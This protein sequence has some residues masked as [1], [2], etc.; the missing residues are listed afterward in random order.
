MKINIAFVL[1]WLSLNL[2]AQAPK[3]SNDFLNIGVGARG[4]AMSGAA[5]AHTTTVQA[6]YWNPACLPYNSATFQVSA[7]HAEWFSGIGNYDY[8]GFGKSLDEESRS[9]GALSLIRMSIDQIPNTLRLRGP[10]GSIDYSRIE[11]FSVADY[12]LL[13]SYGRKL[14]TG[15]WSFGANTKVI[16]RSFGSFAKAWGFGIDAG[17]R[18]TSDH[19]WFSIMGRDITTTFNAYKFSFTNEEKAV[20]QQTN[21]DIPISSVEYTLPKIISSLAYKMRCSDKIYLLSALDLEFSGNGTKSSLISSSKFN[22]DPKIG[23]ELDYNQRVFLRVGA[24]NFQNVLADDGSGSK[25]FS[26]YPTAG[27]GLRIAKITI[28]YAMTN[29]GNAGLGLY[30][31][32]FSLNLDF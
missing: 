7:Q 23:F 10:D 15:P 20:L 28:D 12:A 9:F 16:H 31:H 5:G 3:F 21:N 6:A 22:V 19:F 18:Y 24:G 27:L 4:M 11:E 13:V 2:V 29:I 8:V 25:D 30:S 14:G 17:L 32:Y 26:F 1:I